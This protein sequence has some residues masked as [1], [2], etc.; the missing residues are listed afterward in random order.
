MPIQTPP[1]GVTPRIPGSKLSASSSRARHGAVGEDALLA[2]DVG[3]EG[4]ERADALA[5]SALDRAPLL[6]ADHAR[7]RVDVE[8]DLAVGG[9]EADA[10]DRD[11]VADGR[12]ERR[13]VVLGDL[14]GAG[15]LE[16][17]RVL[18]HDQAGTAGVI[19]LAKRGRQKSPQSAFTT[20]GMP[21]GSPAIAR[22]RSA[23]GSAARCAALASSRSQPSVARRAA[24]R[25]RRAPRAGSRAGTRA[26]AR[27]VDEAA[28]P[29]RRG[30]RGSGSRRAPR[31]RRR[32]SGSASPRAPRAARG[33]GR[34][35]RA[36][37]CRATASAR[38][39]RAPRACR[40]RGCSRTSHQRNVGSGIAPQRSSTSIAST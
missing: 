17:V 24:S 10:A 27:R 26:V 25:R 9:A 34:A 18:G 14:V 3:D 5:E 40:S 4:V 7:D 23:P 19:V 33:T 12:G 15:L 11:L 21:A 32:A 30:R 36:P 20:P 31:A 8:L 37:P 6:G 16:G 39:S 35:R 2:V 38:P 29:C 22:W 1:G 28:R 13:E